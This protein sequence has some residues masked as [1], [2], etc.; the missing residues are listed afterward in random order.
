MATKNELKTL[1]LNSTELR[2]FLLFQKL[3]KESGKSISTNDCIKWQFERDISQGKVLSRGWRFYVHLNKVTAALE[4]L[5][6]LKHTGFKQGEFRKEKVY[7][8]P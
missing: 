3:T 7:L 2:L 1:R 8:C 5:G 6:I 4:T